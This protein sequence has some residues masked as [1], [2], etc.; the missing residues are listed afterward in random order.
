M[1]RNKREAE[2]LDA[3]DNKLKSLQPQVKTFLEQKKQE[4]VF[5]NERG[6]GGF[7]RSNKGTINSVL[8]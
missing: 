2:R 7:R 8:F 6:G 3:L 5:E 4:E 1:E